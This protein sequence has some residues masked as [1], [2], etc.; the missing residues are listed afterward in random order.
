MK[1]EEKKKKEEIKAEEKKK[2]E[3]KKTL[4]ENKVWYLCVVPYILL[5][6]LS[7]H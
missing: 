5:T 2:K 7:V 1:A 3:E 6:A 4:Q